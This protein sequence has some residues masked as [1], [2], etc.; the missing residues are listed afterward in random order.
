MQSV[1]C[2]HMLGIILLHAYI[3]TYIWNCHQEIHV[4]CSWSSSP[5][6]LFCSLL[7]TTLP[8]DHMSSHTPSHVLVVTMCVS[9]GI[10]YELLR[11]QSPYSLS[12]SLDDCIWRDMDFHRTLSLSLSHCSRVHQVLLCSLTKWSLFPP[13]LSLIC[14]FLSCEVRRESSSGFLHTP[15]NYSI[16]WYVLIVSSVNNMLSSQVPISFY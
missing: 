4:G 2:H 11:L 5:W 6:W 1:I 13:L 7:P 15:S 16:F 14:G 10:F 8:L 9:Y 3:H 12:L